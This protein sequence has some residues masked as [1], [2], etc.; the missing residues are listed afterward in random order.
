MD[1]AE[2]WHMARD[3]LAKCFTEVNGRVHVR[4]LTY[5]GNGET[6]CAEIWC[7]VRVPLVMRVAED[8][9]YLHERTCNCT[10]I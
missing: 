8:G 10:N 6:D 1:Y 4:A 9:R 7:A 5:L 3:P 2:I